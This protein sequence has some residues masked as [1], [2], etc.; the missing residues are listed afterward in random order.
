MTKHKKVSAAAVDSEEV[1]LTA[2]KLVTQITYVLEGEVPVGYQTESTLYTDAAGE[3]VATSL[4]VITNIPVPPAIS[5]QMS[6]ET[7]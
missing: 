1:T 6:R 7:D 2:R 5:Q 3:I 4:P